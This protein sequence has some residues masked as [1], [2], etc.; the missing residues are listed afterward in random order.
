MNIDTSDTTTLF[1]GTGFAI[2]GC[3]IWIFLTYTAMGMARKRGRR[4]GVW[5]ALTFITFGIAIFVLA[6]LPT[7]A[8][9]RAPQEPPAVAAHGV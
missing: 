6:I 5:A 8:R 9:G 7:Q 3:F 1:L 2:L 4:P